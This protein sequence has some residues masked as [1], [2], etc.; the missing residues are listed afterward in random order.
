[1]TQETETTTGEPFIGKELG[2]TNFRIDAEALDH[3][4]GSLEVPAPAASDIAPSMLANNADLTTRAYFEND[5]GNLWLRQEWELHA[6]LQPDT[7]Y[8]ASGRVID[9]YPRR[10]RTIVVTE[11]TLQDVAGSVA[12]IQRH[13]QSFVT[14][15]SEGKATLRDP[16]KKEG[17]RSFEIPEGELIEG[18]LHSVSLE[19]CGQFFHGRRNYHTDKEASAE[20]GFEDVVVG[21]RMT[22]SYLGELLDT[23]LGEPWRRSGRMLVKF[24]NIVWPNETVR[25][26]AVLTGPT[27]DEPSRRGLFAWVEKGD[28]TIAIVAEASLEA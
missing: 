7:P 24:T 23:Q 20:L 6:P 21:G 5:F 3:Y 8:Q 13:H 28:G 10:D 27:E 22:M 16:K 9:I 2:A 26:R 1:M 17:A 19:M 12:A 14:D 11:T 4:Y 25:A 18:D 15:Q